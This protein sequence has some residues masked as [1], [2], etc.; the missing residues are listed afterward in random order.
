M[1]ITPTLEGGL[2][3]DVEAPADWLLLRQLLEDATNRPDSLAAE[4]GGMITEEE[5]KEDWE[6]LVVPDLDEQFS[7]SLRQV[8]HSIAVAIGKFGGDK[9]HL[10]ISP[11][12][13]W[14]WYS[15]LNQARLAIEDRY[16]FC[17]PGRDAKEL[18]GDDKRRS[19]F[20]R[21]HLYCEIQNLLLEHVLD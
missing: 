11:E 12:D 21:S 5:L 15:A 9:G 13:G 1:K 2:R 16:Q 4:L 19:V 6:E 18:L 7:Q 14:N 20:L 8:R 17:A 10:W 3:V